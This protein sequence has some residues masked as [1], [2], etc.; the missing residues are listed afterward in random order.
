[1][2]LFIHY[3]RLKTVKDPDEVAPDGSTIK[4][5]MEALSKGTADDIK[6]CGNTCDAY[7]KKKLLGMTNFS[8][9]SLFA[10]LHFLCSQSH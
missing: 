5:R 10:N 2:I 9:S 3:E 7:S 4:S 6:S 8:Y 1:M